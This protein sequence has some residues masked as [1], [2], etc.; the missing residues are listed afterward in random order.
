M[1]SGKHKKYLIFLLTF[2][3]EEA[4]PVINFA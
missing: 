4:V 3:F 1:L 2:C